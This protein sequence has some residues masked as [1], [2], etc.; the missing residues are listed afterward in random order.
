MKK[1]A[2]WGGFVDFKLPDDARGDLREAMAVPDY[3]LGVL[4]RLVGS[5]LKI[6][7]RWEDKHDCYAGHMQMIE[8][9]RGQKQW[10]VAVRGSS[11]DRV[12][13]SLDYYWVHVAEEDYWD[14]VAQAKEENFW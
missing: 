3:T 14:V 10:I 4:D 12:L 11:I 6:T 8:L 13:A 7:V 5:G 1:N 9:R 2:N